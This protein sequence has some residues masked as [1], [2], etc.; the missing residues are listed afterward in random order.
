MKSFLILFPFAVAA[1]II[2]AAWIGVI[3]VPGLSPDTSMAAKPKTKDAGAY[4]KSRPLE[5]LPPKQKKEVATTDPEQGHKKLALLWE[6]I[7]N[8]K[9]LFIVE[10]WRDTDL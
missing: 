8:D 9:L 7:E 5:A 3:E 2:G 6:G 10:K 4:Q 1:G